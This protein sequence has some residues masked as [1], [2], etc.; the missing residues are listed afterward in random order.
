MNFLVNLPSIQFTETQNPTYI[1][2][3][4]RITEIVLLDSNKNV[5]V[6]AKTPLPIKRIGTQVFSLKLDF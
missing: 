4:K 1:S 6:I 2:G 3:D 5:L